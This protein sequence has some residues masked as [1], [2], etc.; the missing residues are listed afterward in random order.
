MEKCFWIFN[1][2]ANCSSFRKRGKDDV[3]NYLPRGKDLR[4]I[5]GLDFRSQGLIIVT[6]DAEFSSACRRNPLPKVYRMEC[7][8]RDFDFERLK[9]RE[10]GLLLEGKLYPFE[11]KLF[12]KAERH[13]NLEFKITREPYGFLRRLALIFKIKPLRIERTSLGLFHL[14]RLAPG[15]FRPMSIKEIG[16]AEEMLK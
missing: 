14:G 13:F 6:T 8:S 3:F 7:K 11:V 16:M 12:G 15:T 1:K 2:P 5:D 4:L 10:K 9:S